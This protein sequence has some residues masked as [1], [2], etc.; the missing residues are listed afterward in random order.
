MHCS[1]T[2]T[3]RC[4]ICTWETHMDIQKG[5]YTLHHVNIHLHINCNAPCQCRN[6]R[7]VTW[8]HTLHRR[9]KITYGEHS[10]DTLRHGSHMESHT[11]VLHPEREALTSWHIH[12]RKD[13]DSKCRQCLSPDRNRADS[14][15][16]SPIGGLVNPVWDRAQ[17]NATLYWCWG[18]GDA[19]VKTQASF[20]FTFLEEKKE[21]NF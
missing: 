15:S 12:S 16:H 4:F 2:F 1:L 17:V 9:I 14:F 7:K 19:E 6:M 11:Y 18:K 20:R 8:T 13:A 10:L 5:K 21:G 3:F